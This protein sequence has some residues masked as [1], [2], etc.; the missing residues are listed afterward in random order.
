LKRA[1]IYVFEVFNQGCFTIEVDREVIGAFTLPIDPYAKCFGV[2]VVI[3]VLL[4]SWTYCMQ[5][6]QEKI[7]VVIGDIT[8]TSLIRRPVPIR[9]SLPARNSSIFSAFFNNV[10]TVFNSRVLSP[11]V[12]LLSFDKCRPITLCA[13]CLSFVDFFSKSLWVP[14][15]CFD[16]SDGSLQPSWQSVPF[17]PNRSYNKSIKFYGTTRSSLRCYY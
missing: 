12:L 16:A 8:F 6:L 11:P 2:D 4:C 9:I 3:L 17:P 1:T 14:L 13:E 15:H 5:V 7:P 10:L